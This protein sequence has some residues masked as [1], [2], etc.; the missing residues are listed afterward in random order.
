MD[1]FKAPLLLTALA[2]LV[3]AAPTEVVAGRVVTHHVARDLPTLTRVQPTLTHVAHSLPTLTRV[4]QAT[5]VSLRVVEPAVESRLVE[6]VVGINPQYNFGYS[7]TDAV[8]GDSKNRQETR[9]GDHVTGSYS[10]ADPDGRIRTVTYEAGPDIGFVAKVTY[11]GAD[12]PVAI[13]LDPPARS[14]SSPLPAVEEPQASET[15]VTRVSPVREVTP[16]HRLTSIRQLTPVRSVAPV[17]TV[18]QP[19]RTVHAVSQPT[20]VRTVQPSLAHVRAVPVST[21]HAVDHLPVT[22][23]REVSSV[24]PLDLSQFRFVSSARIV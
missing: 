21:V 6:E 12:G 19:I 24:Q 22:A 16:V 8:T 1:L 7:V 10:V 2:T 13:P 3:S 14:V 9:D 4:Q 5:P 23:V 15:S 11:D 18:V 17:Q 20:V